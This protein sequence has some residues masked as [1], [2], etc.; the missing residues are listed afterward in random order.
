MLLTLE[1]K[2]E[3]KL[4]NP[5]K[6]ATYIQ[7]FL[8]LIATFERFLNCFT[9]LFIKEPLQGVNLCTISRSLFCKSL[10]HSVIKEDV[11]STISQSALFSDSDAA[12]VKD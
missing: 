9:V 10:Y 11:F 3:N 8:V 1:Y 4:A 6:S 7:D 2:Q 12:P 5:N